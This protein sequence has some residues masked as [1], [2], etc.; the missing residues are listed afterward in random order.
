[1][2]IK[3]LLPAV[4]GLSV[5][6]V[7][8]HAVALSIHNDPK[9]PQVQYTL[10]TPD[11]D[12]VTSQVIQPNATK[13]WTGDLND[14]AEDNLRIFYDPQG[15]GNYYPCGNVVPRNAAVRFKLVAGPG[16]LWQNSC[17]ID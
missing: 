12:M 9:D 17:S 14:K 16:G 3:K 5:T 10:Y 7:S 4:F 6:L 2:K 1:M 11:G 8:L 15:M 13:T